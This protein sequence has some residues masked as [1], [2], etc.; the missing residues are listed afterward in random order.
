M[1]RLRLLLLVSLLFIPCCDQ[2]A[3]AQIDLSFTK[4]KS[5]VGA[6]NP[7]VVG[8]RILID[9]DSRPTVVDVA[10]IRV[11][12][13]EKT[14]LKARKSLFEAVE[15]TKLTD[16]EYLLIGDGDYLVEAN[17]E[18]YERELK[19][20]IKPGPPLP[21]KPD[22]PVTPDD[23]DVPDDSLTVISKES[24]RAMQD[25]VQQMAVD[26]DSLSAEVQ[27]GRVKT[28][29]EASAFSTPKDVATRTVFKQSMAK[30]LEPKLGSAELPTDA[31]TVFTEVATGFRS[32][33]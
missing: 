4:A 17:S 16:S 12:S 22:D 3:Q 23:P 5:L 9:D 26:M 33:K 7:R 13:Q 27:A 24:R 8:D 29:L 11:N 19:V 21:P 2:V 18:N 25:F 10:I 32:V 20:T 28:M 31:A 1:N 30:V 14:R 15:L 6:T